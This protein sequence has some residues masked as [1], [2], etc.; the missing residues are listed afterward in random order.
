[1]RD[2]QTTER[3]IARVL[4]M[5]VVSVN[6]AIKCGSI[7]AERKGGL[8][9]V[10][11]EAASAYRGRP[12]TDAEW[13]RRE[14]PSKSKSQGDAEKPDMGLIRF[15]ANI[16]TDQIERHL[17]SNGINVE[18]PAFTDETVQAAIRF[19]IDRL[20]TKGDVEVM[21]KSAERQ[22]DRLWDAWL[23]DPIQRAQFPD[24]PPPLNF[25]YPDPLEEEL[26]KSFRQSGEK[27]GT[28]N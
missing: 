22:R 19:G 5:P 27:N 7:P 25:E 14:R 21:L 15:G 8:V 12:I 24:G 23:L 9:L 10:T 28:K 2:D 16:R 18:L 6:R 4:N 26:R 1:M 20:F 11:R 3:G 17:F 13:A